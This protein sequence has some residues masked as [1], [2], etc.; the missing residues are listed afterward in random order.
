[1]KHKESRFVPHKEQTP[2]PVQTPISPGPEKQKCVKSSL[3]TFEIIHNF[4]YNF[5]LFHSQ[6]A[7]SQNT[8]PVQ[9]GQ[10]LSSNKSHTGL[11]KMKQ[12]LKFDK[13]GFTSFCFSGP[14]LMLFRI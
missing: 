8:V 7:A 10:V 14:E 4:P 3:I 11:R 12:Y 6:M 1:M 9:L 13:T 5:K 2:L